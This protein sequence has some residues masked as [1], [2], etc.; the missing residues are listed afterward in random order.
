MLESQAVSL[1]ELVAP[2]SKGSVFLLVE[3]LDAETCDQMD[4]AL[5]II[6]GIDIK[7]DSTSDVF[8][9]LLSHGYLTAKSNLSEEMII[10]GS[11]IIDFFR[12]KKL[13]TS[14][15]AYL[16]IDGK[17]VENSGDSLASSYDMLE[18][19]QIPKYLEFAG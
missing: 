9:G 5:T 11:Q 2:L 4:V 19:L 12:Q 6:K 1:E 13:R 3:V 10:K 15:K 18:E 8:D 16:F 7:S 14:A 17:C